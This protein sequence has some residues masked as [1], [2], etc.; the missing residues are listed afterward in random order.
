M[1]DARWLFTRTVQCP[2]CGADAT[3]SYALADGTTDQAQQFV[4]LCPN[5][6]SLPQ[7]EIET[8]V[9]AET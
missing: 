5:L 4:F 9:D 7:R 6:C 1:S 2:S 3:L 8:L